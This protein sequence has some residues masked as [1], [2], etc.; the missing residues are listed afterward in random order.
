VNSK[1]LLRVSLSWVFVRSEHRNA[2]L[3][4]PGEELARVAFPIRPTSDDAK[5]SQR[6]PLPWKAGIYP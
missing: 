5:A 2:L 6:D 4:H 3:F 1:F